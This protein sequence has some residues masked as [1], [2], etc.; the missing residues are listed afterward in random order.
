MYELT[1][2]QH[3]SSAHFLRGYEGKCEAL[4]GH[5]WEVEAAVAGHELDH[6]GMLI[7][8]KVVKNLLKE[9]L[10]GLDHVCLN[11]LPAFAADNP[12]AENIARFIFRE[13]GERLR[14]SYPNVRVAW[15]KVW[16][17]PGSGVLYREP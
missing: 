9:I 15:I 5:N 14:N 3:F 10:D 13:L 17:S 12:S 11:E 7:D 16:E 1:V 6:L 2:R 8:F 4:H